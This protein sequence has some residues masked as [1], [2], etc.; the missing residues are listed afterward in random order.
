MATRAVL[1]P[2]CTHASAAMRRFA[3][4]WVAVAACAALSLTRVQTATASAAVLASDFEAMT[5]SQWQV[6]YETATAAMSL[7]RVYQRSPRVRVKLMVAQRVSMN[8]LFTGEL[9]LRQQLSEI[10]NTSVARVQLEYLQTTA[11]REEDEA[12]YFASFG[13][14]ALPE[15]AQ[16][17]AGVNASI[18]ALGTVV[19][20][21][22]ER[23]IEKVRYG[24]VVRGQ[25]VTISSLYLFGTHV[26]V[27]DI[28]LDGETFYPIDFRPWVAARVAILPASTSVLS[29]SPRGSATNPRDP[30]VTITAS[31]NNNSS[32]SSSDRY[33]PS[34][35][36]FQNLRVR[37]QFVRALWQWQLTTSDIIMREGSAALS[38]TATRAYAAPT[39]IVNLEFHVNDAAYRINLHNY[40]L[41]SSLA[42]AF[43]AIEPLWT[44]GAIDVDIPYGLISFP[45]TFMATTDTNSSSSGALEAYKSVE[46]T[47]TLTNILFAW[48]ETRKWRILDA[49]HTFIVNY[50]CERCRVRYGRITLPLETDSVM[51]THNDGD[52][53][54]KEASMVTAYSSVASDPINTVTYS[55]SF[56]IDAKNEDVDSAEFASTLHNYMASHPDLDLRTSL[57]FLDASDVDS[58]AFAGSTVAH[59]SVNEWN[60]SSTVETQHKTPIVQ[61]NLT[62]ASVQPIATSAAKIASS[63][64]D[65]HRIRSALLMLL[66]QVNAWGE[67]IHLIST[68]VLPLDAASDD[69]DSRLLLVYNVDIKEESQRRGI[70]ALFLSRRM[71]S[72][73]EEYMQHRVQVHDRR[74]DIRVDGSVS[75]WGLK[76]PGIALTLP[77][78]A[79]TVMVSS[80][81]DPVA[82]ATKVY[83][84]DLPVVGTNPSWLG[85]A[86]NTVLASSPLLASC[87]ALAPPPSAFCVAIQWE[88][89]F[90][91]DVLFLR[92]IESNFSLE[93]SSSAL[94]TAQLLIPGAGMTTKI[95]AA[96]AAG[97]S[98]P[99]IASPGANLSPW[100]IYVNSTSLPALN[101]DLRLRFVLE[102]VAPE[103]SDGA[104][105]AFTLDVRLRSPHALDDSNGGEPAA[106]VAK[107]SA[108]PLFTAA[109]DGSMWSSSS[110]P[111]IWDPFVTATPTVDSNGIM[112]SA[113]LV[114]RIHK[115]ALGG[116]FTPTQDVSLTTAVCTACMTKM[117]TCTKSLECRAISTCFRSV[118]DRDPTIYAS[119]LAREY[120]SG[121][122]TASMF[123]L[124]EVLLQC[125]SMDDANGSIPLWSPVARAVFL[126]GLLC[127]IDYAC[128]I[129]MNAAHTKRLVL[130]YTPLEQTITFH[131]ANFRS[132]LQFLLETEVSYDSA[133]ATTTNRALRTF[134][135]LLPDESSMNQLQAMLM[136]LYGDPH[137]GTT[138]R[139][140]L[141]VDDGTDSAV[142]R[143]QY[144]FILANISAMRALP[145]ILATQDDIPTIRTTSVSDETFAIQIQN[146]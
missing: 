135:D 87:S 50:A 86:P 81:Y 124:P 132:T 18:V 26:K 76:L 66:Q 116:L 33:S 5:W 82:A 49:T 44:I 23:I 9:I 64:F 90:P 13:L 84:Y 22:R 35:D 89:D 59:E 143:I 120:A 127:A 46:W 25:N 45:R 24:N 131:R 63:V 21:E 53:D 14:S 125:L 3:M 58:G 83:R 107:S 70:E 112:R 100:L 141:A 142:V 144:F 40:L 138:I 4:L 97:L 95:A 110:S 12:V 123:A 111:L 51:S 17:P 7:E 2:R 126:D 105:S 72:T 32:S 91:D 136:E 133:G 11:L 74:V 101:S 134:S 140:Q 106:R 19:D 1:R 30:K 102:F 98:A 28:V 57:E 15:P 114:V 43:N 20:T 56:H 78:A 137:D 73:I 71:R 129:E 103:V 146:I 119:L 37:F 75:Y 145:Y 113:G 36:A 52:E 92:Q 6:L 34:Q 67:H 117:E 109:V 96:S 130:T 38:V 94:P 27:V 93:S 80:S 115:Q 10:V 68:S 77:A 29:E 139:V 62:L 55:L 118:V 60:S 121:N 104:T 8:Q 31:N 85:T 128:A 65:L 79:D 42:Q 88:S 108:L 54:T 99:W 16:V 122:A 41:N 39:T 61:L 47:L 48:V 69:F